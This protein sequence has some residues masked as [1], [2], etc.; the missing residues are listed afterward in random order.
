MTCDALSCKGFWSH[1]AWCIA[2]LKWGDHNHITQDKCKTSKIT[3]LLIYMN[4]L[5]SFKIQLVITPII[6]QNSK[7]LSITYK[8]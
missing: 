3:H 8:S 2:I 6:I 1:G 5:N 7:V 4:T